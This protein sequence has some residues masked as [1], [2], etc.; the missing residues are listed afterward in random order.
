MKNSKLEGKLHF[1]IMENI[2]LDVRF[3]V[4]TMKNIVLLD[5]TSCS[6]VDCFQRNL[7]SPSSG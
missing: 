6:H 2:H 4:L 1:F 7:Q 5:V 3:E